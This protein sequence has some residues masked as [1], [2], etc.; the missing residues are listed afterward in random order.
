[1][2]CSE[3]PARRA[4]PELPVTTSG[5][6]LLRQ[7]CRGPVVVPRG[8]AHGRGGELAAPAD[9]PGWRGWGVS[10]SSR[11]R[12]WARSC[13]RAAAVSRAAPCWVQ[14]FVSLLRPT[15]LFPRQLW[16]SPARPVCCPSCALLWH[17]W[18]VPGGSLSLL[19]LVHPMAEAIGRGARG[20]AQG[21]L[22]VWGLFGLAWV[23]FFL[24][25]QEAL[26]ALVS[27][28][29]FAPRDLAKMP[30]KSAS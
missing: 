8:A 13:R 26:H 10:G 12:R 17:G 16:S 15:G 14:R 27:L 20:A 6:Q 25:L 22:R 5:L 18:A 3:H 28:A 2:P 4:A 19:F 23:F 30:T 11:D 29:P 1:M 9:P 21:V 24:F 7:R